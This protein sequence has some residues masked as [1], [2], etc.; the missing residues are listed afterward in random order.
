MKYFFILSQLCFFSC[1]FYSLAGSIP[2]HIKSISIPLVE[3]QTSDYNLSEQLTDKIISQFNESG[4]LSIQDEDKAHSILKGIIKKITDGP[5]SY[6]KNESVSEFR[7]KI[8]VKIEWYD[9][10][11]KKILLKKIIQALEL[12]G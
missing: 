6:N 12:M 1:G 4:I 2:T 5:Y 3:N 11:N 7:Y 10:A 8:D 9:N